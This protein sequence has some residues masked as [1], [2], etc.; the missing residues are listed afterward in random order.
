MTSHRSLISLLVLVSAPSLGADSAP[1]QPLHFAWP[2]M[3]CAVSQ[4]LES[5]NKSVESQY[6]MTVSRAGEKLRVSFL[7]FHV[8]DSSPPVAPQARSNFLGA[9]NAIGR[10]D[11]ERV[12]E[13]T[14]GGNFLHAESI[15]DLHKRLQDGKAGSI[16]M[17]DNQESLDEKYRA[18]WRDFIGAW[19]G[20]S[21]GATTQVMIEQTES[22][23]GQDYNVPTDV[24]ANAPADCQRGGK[25]VRCVTIRT[26]FLPAYTQP[27]R[28][29]ANSMRRE[30]SSEIVLEPDTMIPH[31]WMNQVRYRG[32]QLDG[33]VEQRR[34]RTFECQPGS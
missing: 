19:I 12:F 5:P 32:G 8:T 9:E 34:T 15:A 25:T 20:L 30:D 2:E 31:S 3:S 21:P 26:Q 23:Y 6:T 22:M 18:R 33:V 24:T 1:V 13:V 7:G 28:S 29:D 27:G 14:D 17:M 16:Y 4:K 11:V 10:P